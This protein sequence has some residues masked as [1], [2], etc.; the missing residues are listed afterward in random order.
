MGEGGGGEEGRVQKAS[1][2]REKREALATLPRLINGINN[3][4]TQHRRYTHARDDNCEDCARGS[5]E[6][7]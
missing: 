6:W 7:A 1:V 5:K 3:R 4:C 2:R